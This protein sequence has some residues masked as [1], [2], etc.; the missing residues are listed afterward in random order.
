MKTV[1]HMLLFAAI[2]YA[3]D[4][5]CHCTVCD[6][7]FEAM[8][9]APLPGQEADGKKTRTLR[10]EIDDNWRF[11]FII[12]FLITGVGSEVSNAKLE[13]RLKALENPRN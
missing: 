13:K 6:L 5:Q 1:F 11:G 10:A 4:Y 7:A 3:I 8:E 12:M 9:K 2:I